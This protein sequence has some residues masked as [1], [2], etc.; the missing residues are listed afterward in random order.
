[1]N[2]KAIV[3]DWLVTNGYE[4]L[5][6]ENGECGCDLN[7]LMCCD[8]SGV[9]WCLPAYKLKCEGCTHTCIED[10]G[11]MMSVN[12]ECPEKEYENARLF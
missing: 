12:R 6:N 3:R 7:D 10:Y 4:G 9:D 8:N 11:Y 1:M 5:F 2:V